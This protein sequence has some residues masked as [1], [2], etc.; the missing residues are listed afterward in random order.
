MGK[1]HFATIGSLL[2]EP[3]LRI[4]TIKTADRRVF[5]IA[6]GCSKWLPAVFRMD[7]F[8]AQASENGRPMEDLHWTLRYFAHWNALNQFS[9]HFNGLFNFA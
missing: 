2:R 3:I 1:I 9:M 7:F 8:A 5:K 4:T 6:A